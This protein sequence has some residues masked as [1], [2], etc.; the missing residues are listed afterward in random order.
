MAADFQLIR[1]RTISRLEPLTEAAHVWAESHVSADVVR[2]G[3]AILVEHGGVADMLRDLSA[4]GLT[5]ER[6]EP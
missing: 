1:Q 4:A 5:V 6:F 3:P 2:F